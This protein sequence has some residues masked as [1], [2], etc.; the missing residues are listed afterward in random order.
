MRHRAFT[1]IELLVV[2][3]IIAIVIGMLLP[4]LASARRAAQTT[5]CLSKIRQLA[6]ANQAYAAEFG[7][8]VPYSQFVHKAI[9]MNGMPIGVNRRWCWADDTAGDPMLAFKNGL[10]GRY[11]TGPTAIAGCPAFETPQ[12]VIDQ[13]AALGMAYPVAVHYGYNGL[14][15]GFKHANFSV[16]DENTPGYATWIGYRPGEVRRPSEIVMFADAGQLFLGQV[17]PMY[18]LCPP[19]AVNF[20]N[21]NPRAFATPMVHARHGKGRANVAWVDGH[22][23]TEIVQFYGDQTADERAKKLGFLAPDRGG[24]RSNEW[25]FV[26]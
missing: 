22:C 16:I 15:L 18:V 25:M 26:K 19:I 7:Q 24:T 6:I 9:A 10:I 14:L 23:T 8:Y 20:P 13:Y 4:A 21:G 3:G 5:V 17:I 12:A 2:I 1:L 11:L